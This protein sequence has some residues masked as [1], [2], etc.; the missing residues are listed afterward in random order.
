MATYC[1]AFLATDLRQFPGWP[2]SA[3]T[4]ASAAENSADPQAPH[5]DPDEAILY[6]HDNYVVTEGAL[7]DEGTVFDKVTSEWIEF[8]TGTLAFSVPDYSSKVRT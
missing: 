1:K 2:Q 3:Q 7:R 8:C 5:T 4:G 6:L